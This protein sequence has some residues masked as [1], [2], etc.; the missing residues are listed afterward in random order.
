[1]TPGTPNADELVL[2]V[3]NAT[4]TQYL[5]TARG[6]VEAMEKPTQTMADAGEPDAGTNGNAELVWQAMID[7]IL[8]EQE[9]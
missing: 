4:W 1:M 5:A 7:A 6:A 2:L 8:E 9:S 3:V